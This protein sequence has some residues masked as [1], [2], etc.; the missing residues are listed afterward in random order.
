MKR[1]LTILLFSSLFAQAQTGVLMVQASQPTAAD[2]TAGVFT[3]ALAGA[4]VTMR[5][6]HQAAWTAF[7]DSLTTAGLWGTKVKF[8]LP[9]YGTTAS[10]T[11][12]DAISGDSLVT[13]MGSVGY[14]GGVMGNGTDAYGI[15]NVNLQTLIGTPQ[16]AHFGLYQKTAAVDNGAGGLGQW[17]FGVSN[18]AGTQMV[19]L[20]TAAS[21]YHK[22]SIGNGFVE[23]A[24]G[25]NG[26]FVDEQGVFLANRTGSTYLE[27]WKNDAVIASNTTADATAFLTTTPYILALNN[28]GAAFGHAARALGCVWGGTG[29]TTA[30]AEY[31]I[32]QVQALMFG[33]ERNVL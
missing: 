12:L 22:A 5:T 17:D 28:N 13:W 24:W 11:A 30:E 32:Q 27:L 23:A 3:D 2:S 8:F 31:I 25:G 9:F 4:G 6:S 21:Y 19:K 10:T 33:W 18:A 7:V 20:T 14:G 16:S 26:V 29:L 15:L 1:L